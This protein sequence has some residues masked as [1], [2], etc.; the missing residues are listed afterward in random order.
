MPLAEIMQ[1]LTAFPV[2][3]QNILSAYLDLRPGHRGK[4]LYPIFLKNRFSEVSKLFPPRSPE[5]SQLKEEIKL[6]H[7]FLDEEL[8]P[9]W[10]GLALFASVPA[11]LFIAVP[12]VYPPPNSLNFS[13]YPHLFSLLVQN[14]FYQTHVIVVATSRQASLHLIRLG[15]LA[16]Q[17]TLSWENKHT[18]RFG[19][20]GWSLPKF[21]RHL[22]EHLK[23]RSKEIVENLEKLMGPEKFE[24]LFLVAE[25]GIEGELKKQMPSSFR[26]KWLTLAKADIHDPIPKILGTAAENLRAIY[27]Q[28]AENLADHILKEVEPMGRG[29]SGPEPSLSAL[30]S[31]QVEQIVLDTDFVSSGWRCE[32]CFSL[33]SGGL[34]QV[35]PYCQGNISPSNLR[36]EIVF[37]AKSQGVEILFTEK[38]PPLLEAGGI[39]VLYKYKSSGK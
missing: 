1:K 33:G 34:P 4:K 18:T 32:D 2:G 11:E 27:I 28:K 21:Q 15:N 35:C 6:I 36:E 12:M 5:Q 37:K 3:R 23:Q 14:P 29:A 8:N 38:F 20:M 9:A 22:Q 26:K 10:K 17:L 30:Q 31:H 16:K 24:Y 7:K 19:R 39:A 25:E 13:P